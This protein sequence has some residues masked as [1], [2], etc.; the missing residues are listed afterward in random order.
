MESAIEE[1]RISRRRRRL[2]ALM[3][4]AT[5]LWSA[6]PA[7]AQFVS[8]ASIEGAVADESGGALPGVV[9]TLTGPALQV[10]QLTQTTAADGR[11]QFAQLRAG[12][13]QLR[14][15]L[16]GFQPVAREDLQVGVGF[17]AKVNVVLKIGSINET[18]SVTGASPIVD[19][20]TITS[21]KT[22][23][24][25]MVNDLLPT[26]RMV[27]DMS[28][29]IPGMTTTSAPNIGQLGLG[30]TGGYSA[31]GDTGQNV[32]IDGLEIRSNTYPDFSTAEEVDVKL[33]ANSADVSTPGA[34]WNIV[35][36]SGGNDA[37][38]R[39]AEQYI[40]SSLQGNNLDSTLIAQGLSYPDRLEYFH[41]FGADL[42]GRVVRDKLWFYGNF[43]NRQNKRTIPGLA[44][45]P[46]NDGVYGTVDDVPQLP[47]VSTRNYTGKLSYQPSPKYQLVAFFAEDYSVNDGAGVSSKGAPQFI[48]YESATYQTF[49]PTNW[50]GEF[51]AILRDN[52]IFN[53]QSGRVSYIVNYADTPACDPTQPATF[54]RNT[55]R[56]TGCSVDTVAG[57]FAEAIRPRYNWVNQGN[58]TFVPRGGVFGGSHE[59]KAGYRSWIQ[60]GGTNIP[61]HAAGNY[62]LT[63]DVVGGVP[64]QPVEMVT[65]NAPV[66]QANREHSFAVYLNDKWEV[67]GR[68]TLN[69]GIRYDYDHSFLPP[70]TKEQGQF[71]AG[72]S[73]PQFEGNTW[74]DV[75]PRVAFAFDLT[76]NARSV[77]K[78]TY[79]VY[80]DEM[81]DS[82]ASPFN[83]NGEVAT[84]Y[85]WH[86][87]NRNGNYNPGE[88]DLD[89]NHADFISISG[90]A[91]NIFNDGLARPHQQE[92]TASFDREVMANTSARVAYV[93]KRMLGAI[94][95]VNVLRPVSA[96]G[97]ALNRRDPGPD[98]IV[99]TADDGPFVTVY[100]Y[101]RAFAGSA[102]VGNE[103]LNRDDNRADHYGT[104]EFTLNRRLGK[105]WGGLASFSATKNHRWLVGNVQSPNDDYY[106]IDETWNWVF[107]VNGTMRLPYDIVASGLFDLQPGVRGQRTYV[108]RAADPN[109]GPALQGQTTVTLRLDPFGTEVGPIRPS[110]NV[111]LGKTFTL[112]KGRLQASIDGLNML[113]TNTFW[114]MTFASGPTYGYGTTFTSPRAFQLGLSYQF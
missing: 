74:K 103:M 16:S 36:K 2:S 7:A 6:G 1:R 50:R 85:R 21:S 89:V 92:I 91:N 96:F 99:G 97:L 81:A 27:G 75:S 112:P 73:F 104:V 114:A 110:L 95:T 86:D 34:V 64:H 70:Q 31:Y 90:A 68:L 22:L 56:F 82:F 11:Y 67:G 79:G 108:F 18:V 4:I 61:N 72:G 51:R 102:F 80:N 14:Y 93:Y 17:A 41:D 45:S 28:R 77:I 3:L 57:N 29:L 66:T 69:L 8:T 83:Q 113:N 87:L 48:P 52:L 46:G 32:M 12:V 53:A 23:S 13:Y 58:L 107:K 60:Q 84:T 59:F 38:G 35:T 40:N 49:N 94:S 101:P 71:G 30:T 63:F 55:Q 33:F 24:A 19:V 43:R 20:T 39:L 54:D 26:S 78:A 109:G 42:G 37:H 105:R 10:P 25:S 76:G 111:R 62:Q 44:A 65:F 98:G 9:V 100:D 15:E 5:V 106:P 47:V 88:V